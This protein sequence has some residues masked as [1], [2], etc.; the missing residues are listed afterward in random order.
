MAHRESAL[1]KTHQKKESE[2]ATPSFL[3]R[4]L[5]SLFQRILAA[6]LCGLLVFAMV[7]LPIPFFNHCAKALGRAITFPVELPFST[8]D[9]NAVW[10]WLTGFFDHRSTPDDLSQTSGEDLTNH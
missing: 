8:D 3:Q 6:L 7:K 4:R 10:Q 5:R 2:R 1:T 9:H